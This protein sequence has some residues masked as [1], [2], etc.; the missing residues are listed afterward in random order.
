MTEVPEV[1]GVKQ[2]AGDLKLM[3]DLM[4]LAPPA[5]RIFSAVDA[6]ISPSFTLGAHGAIAGDPECRA[7][8]CVALWARSPGDHPRADRPPPPPA[9]AWTRCLG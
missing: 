9:A 3:A 7:G 4:L 8:V 2:S 6:L 1:I 5:S